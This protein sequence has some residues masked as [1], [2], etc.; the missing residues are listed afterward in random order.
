MTGG[1]ADL[2]GRTR[3]ASAGGESAAAPQ[4]VETAQN[5]RIRKLFIGLFGRGP[6]KEMYQSPRYVAT[7]K[8]NK[9]IEKQ[10][11]IFLG[12]PA[13]FRGTVAFNERR[14]SDAFELLISMS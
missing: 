5:P 13:H 8:Q 3:K 7:R 12:L 10:A 11:T 4:N 1:A 14:I 6:Q 9:A 2:G